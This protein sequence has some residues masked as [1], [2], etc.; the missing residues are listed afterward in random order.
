M[1]WNKQLKRKFVDY[2]DTPDRL[3]TKIEYEMIYDCKLYAKSELK[4]MGIK[5][6]EG[7]Y[8]I[9]A[10]TNAR[11]QGTTYYYDP[12]CCEPTNEKYKIYYRMFSDY[13]TELEFESDTEAIEAAKLNDDTVYKFIRKINK[14]YKLGKIWKGKIEYKTD[15]QRNQR[16]IDRKG[17]DDLFV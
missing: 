3:L 6:L 2:R 9:K 4:R 5:P 10:Y 8:G 7:Y 15:K 1:F 17:L 16:M 13:D 11:C 12:L 14:S